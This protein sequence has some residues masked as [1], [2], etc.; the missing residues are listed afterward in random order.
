MSKRPSQFSWKRRQPQRH[1]RKAVVERKFQVESLEERRL[2]AV[3][4]QLVAIS[5]NQGEI[6][7][8]GDVRHIAPRELTFIFDDSQIIDANTLG[9]GIQIVRAGGD[10][11]FGDANDVAIEPGF[12]GVDPDNPNEVIVRFAEALPDDRY[13]IQIIGTGVTPLRNNRGEAFDSQTDL[14]MEF[15]LDLGAQVRAIVPQP[16]THGPGGT[17]EQARNQIEVY[18]ND[19]DL[20]PASA[21]NTDFYKLTLTNDT[22]DNG[23]DTVIPIQEISYD[24]VADKAVLTLA[25]NLDEL[26]GPGTYRLR[27]GTD[28]A[29]PPAPTFFVGSVPDTTDFDSGGAVE[30]RFST[31]TDA[32]S[33][34][35]IVISKAD[36]GLGELPNVAI[37]SNNISLV[38]NSNGVTPSTAQDVIDVMLATGLVTA[39]LISP[40]GTETTDVAAT[41]TDPIEL[42][43]PL[44]GAT[45]DAA[46]DLGLLGSEAKI[47]HSAIDPVPF[48]LDFPGAA[49]EPG[50]RDVDEQTHLL[51]QEEGPPVDQADVD[52]SD[53]E[54]GPAIIAYN[55]QTF[56][57]DDP[58]T[59]LPLTNL[60]TDIQKDRAREI[61]EIYGSLLGIDFI[62]TPQDGLTIVTGDLRAVRRSDSVPTGPLGVIG[63]AGTTNTGL[64]AAVMDNAEIWSDEFAVP[65]DPIPPGDDTF[66]GRLSWFGTAMHEIGHLLGLGHTDELAPFTVMNNEPDLEFDNIPES[67]FPGDHDIVHGQHLHRPDSNDVDLYRVEIADGAQGLF[68]AEVIAERLDNSSLLDSVITVYQEVDV[69]GDIQLEKLAQ[70]DDYFSEDSF[71]ELEL[72]AGVYFVGVSST[73]NDQYNP[74]VSDSSV[75]GTSQGEYDLRLNFRANVLQ[76]L[77]D[78][79][80]DELAGLTDPQPLDGNADGIPGGVF[81]FWFRAAAPSGAEEIGDPRTVFVDKSHTPIAATR[82]TLQNPYTTINEA[83]GQDVFGNPLSIPDG[84][85]ARSGDIVRVVGNGDVDDL[86]GI[87]PYEIGQ[88]SFGQ[89]LSDG[90]TLDLPQGVTMMV[91]AGAVFKF[92]GSAALVGSTSTG[93]DHSASA[94]Q[95][96]GTPDRNVFF[97]SFNDTTVGQ[98]NNPLPDIP[99]SGDWGGVLFNA[100]LDRA[101]GRFDYEAE[102]I[103]LNY[104]NLADIRFGGG[105]VNVGSVVQTIAPIDMRESRATVSYNEITQSASSGISATP[106]TFEE[107]NFHAPEFQP[108]ALTPDGDRIGFTSDYNRIGPDVQGNR[109]LGNS[110]NGMFVRIDTFPGDELRRLTVSGRWDDD[111]I[112]HVVSQ[113]LIVDSEPGGPTGVEFSAPPGTS[114][115][116]RFEL[117]ARPDARLSVDPSVIVKLDGS[118]IETAV[119]AQ[120]ISE[121]Q[122]G[123]AIVFT[124]LM[125]DQYG[126]SGSFDTTNNDS[127]RLPAPGDWGGVYIGQTGS[128]SV[129][130]AIFSYGGGTTSNEGSF[131]GFNVFEIHSA[132]V[133]IAN[134]LFENNAEGTGGQGSETRSGRRSN[135]P[136]AIFVRASQPVL[137]N[138]I[139]RSTNSVDG[140][141]PAAAINI[142]VNALNHVLLADYGRTTGR[143]DQVDGTLD[144]HGPLIVDNRLQMNDIN[145]MLIRSNTLTTQSVWDDADIVH[146]VNGRIYVPDF[147]TYG[148]LRIESSPNESLVVKFS[149]LDPDDM[150]PTI[151]DVAGLV[152]TGRPLDIDDRIGGAI[153]IVGQPGNP[154][155]LSSFFDD[156]VGA[157]LDVNG[158]PQFDTNNDGNGT[159]P[160]P[161]DWES[162]KLD[163]YSHDRNVDVITETE[164]IDLAAAGS[165]GTPVNAQ[166]LGALAANEKGGDDNLRLGFELHGTLSNTA[167]VDVYSFT[168]TGGAEVW[169]DIDRT[170]TSLD[171]VIELVDLNGV[172]LA[173]SDDS[174][175]DLSAMPGAD[176]DLVAG[177]VTPRP[178]GKSPFL[179]VDH[180]TVNPNDAGM[181]LNL[182]GAVGVR[183]TYFVRIRSSHPDLGL[184]ADDLSS[185]Q[186]AGTYQMQVR[187]REVDEVAGSTVQFTDIR[188]ATNAIEIMGQPIHSPLL[189]ETAE[190][191]TDNDTFETAQPIGNILVSDRAAISLS[192]SLSSQD[193]VDWYSFDVVYDSLQLEGGQ[194]GIVFDVDYADG[195]A[196]PNTNLSVF[197]ED[198]QLILFG[199]SSNVADDQPAPGEGSDTDDLSRGSFG[200]QDPFIGTVEFPVGTYYVAVS[201]HARIPTVIAR[202]IGTGDA[203]DKLV[204]LEPIDSLTR[205]ADDRITPDFVT[206][207]A[208]LQFPFDTPQQ[209]ALLITRLLDG[210]PNVERTEN[211]VPFH[212]GD[213]T[214]YVSM[215][216]GLVSTV[217]PFVGTVETTVRGDA[218]PD[219]VFRGIAMRPD[220]HL[221]AATQGTTD[222]TA[223]NFLEIDWSSGDITNT[224]IDDGI[225][226]W[227]LGEET[228]ED[229][230]AG[231]L[232]EGITFG[233]S[234]DTSTLFVVGN[235]GDFDA[236]PPEEPTLPADVLENIVWGLNAT[237]LTAAGPFHPGGVMS[238]D[239]A[240]TAA[241]DL[242]EVGQMAPAGELV[243]G[244]AFASETELFGTTS[245]GSIY[246]MDTTEDR[247]TGVMGAEFISDILN[248]DDEPAILQG[249]TLGPQDVEDGRYARTLLAIDD[250]GTIYAF[251]ADTGDPDNIFLNGESTVLT[252]LGGVNG[253][254]FSTLNENLWHVT[255]FRGSDA[256]HGLEVPFTDTRG[257]A[258]SGEDSFYFGREAGP[259]AFNIGNF[260]ATGDA[261]DFNM[262]GG[263]YGSL[264]TNPFDL[265]DYTSADEPH[266]Y[267]NYFLETKNDG[268][269]SAGPHLDT[270][271]VFVSHETPNLDNSGLLPDDP[272]EWTLLASNIEDDVNLILEDDVDPILGDDDPKPVDGLVFEL[273]DNSGEWRQARIPLGEY[274]GMSDIQLRFDFSS[275]GSM[276]TDTTTGGP[277]L[278]ALAGVELQ[279][280]QTFGVGGT[281]FEFDLGP[282]LILPNAGDVVDG[283]I[284]EIQIDGKST[285]FEFDNDGTVT[286]GHIAVAVEPVDT[287]EV[288]GVKLKRAIDA[289]A[290]F[291]SLL[292]PDPSLLPGGIADL[293]GELIEIN[294]T[295]Y[296][297]DSD[298]MPIDALADPPTVLVTYDPAASAPEIAESL[299]TAVAPDVDAMA[300]QGGV[301]NNLV[302]LS[303]TSAVDLLTPDS[304]IVLTSVDP[305]FSRFTLVVPDP[306]SFADGE[307]L[308]V[309]GTIYE[310]DS[311]GETSNPD[312][313]PP[314]IL[315]PLDPAATVSDTAAAIKD[316]IEATDPAVTVSN[317]SG[318]N[319]DRLIINGASTASLLSTTPPS[320]RLHDSVHL[321]GDRLN[322]EHESDITITQTVPGDAPSAIFVDG[323]N[324]L[325][326]PMGTNIVVK[327]SDSYSAV[328]V[329]DEMI[330]QL[331]G[332][333]AGGFTDTIKRYNQTIRLIGYTADQGPLGYDEVIESDATGGLVSAGGN[334]RAMDNIFQGVF[335]DDLIIG[336]AERGELVFN[337][338]ADTTFSANPAPDPN[339]ILVGDYQ[340][341]ARRGAEYAKGAVFRSFDTNDRLSQSFSIDAPDGSNLQNGQTFTLSDGIEVV[342][343]EYVDRT[344]REGNDTLDVA[345]DSGLVGGTAGTYIGIGTLGDNGDFV[346]GLDVDLISLELTANDEVTFDIDTD[347][348]IGFNSSSFT[349]T[350][351]TYLRVFNEAGEE[352]I[353]SAG[354]NAPGEPPS[355]DPFVFFTAP[356]TGMYYLGISG[357]AR[358]SSIFDDFQPNNDYDVTMPGSGTNAATFLGEYQVEINVNGGT[359]H[360]TVPVAVGYATFD[361]RERVADRI[362]G[363]INSPLVQDT[364]RLDITAGTY[365]GLDR[366]DLFGGDAIVELEPLV[367]TGTTTDANTLRDALLGEGINSVGNAEFLGGDSSAGFFTGGAA[368]IGLESGIVLTTGDANNGGVINTDDGFDGQAS[369]E[370]DDDLDFEFDV[371]TT[372]TTFLEFSFTTES[373]D[374]FFNFVFASEE[375]NEISNSEFNDVFAFF[376]DGGNIALIPGSTNPVSINTV[377]GGNPLGVNPRNSLFY[378]N[379]DP[380]DGGPLVRQFGYD[381]FTD[382]FTAVATDLAPGVHTIKLAISD[383]GD[384]LL[385]S[386]VFLEAGGF[387]SVPEP[388]DLVQGT[389]HDDVGDTNRFRD[390]GQLIIHSNRIFDSAEFSISAGP[391]E[392]DASDGD[393]P[394]QG[395]VSLLREP[396][397]DRL[398]PG[399]TIT[400]NVL[401][402][403]GSGG[404]RFSGDDNSLGPIA[405]VPIGRIIN[406]SIIGSGIDTPE[407]GIQVENNASPTVLNNIVSNLGVGISVDATSVSTVIGGSLF[408]GNGVNSTT[409]VGDF[410]IELGPGEALFV[411]PNNDNYLPQSGSQA[412]D[413]SVDTLGDRPNL[414]T[415]KDPLGISL[416]P[417][418]SPT[419]DQTGQLRV[420]DP[421]VSSPPG[422]GG[423]VFKDRGALDRSDFLGPSAELLTPRDNDADGLD[424]NAN[425]TFV[426]LIGETLSEF[427]VTF[428]DRATA[429]G[430]QQGTGVDGSTVTTDTVMLLRDGVLLEPGLDYT[431]SFDSTNSNIRMTPLAG[432]WISGSYSIVLD[433]MTIA[434]LTGNPLSAN[435]ANGDTAFNINLNSEALLDYGDAPDPTYPTLSGSDGARHLVVA[436]I[437]LGDSITAESDGLQNVAADGDFGDDGVT[438]DTP[439]AIGGTARITVNASSVGVLDAWLD[440]NGDGDWDDAGEQIFAS[441][442]LVAGDNVFSLLIDEVNTVVGDTYA[443]F[444]FSS[445]GGL[446]PTGLA[447]DGEVEDYRVTIEDPQLDFGDAPDFTYHTTLANDGARHVIVPGFQLG[448]SVDAESD[449]QPNGFANGDGSDEDG[450]TFLSPLQKGETST[451]SVNASA[452]GRLDAWFDFDASGDFDDSFAS[453]ERIFSSELLLAGDNVLMFDIP[454]DA[455]VGTSY[456]RFRFSSV[457]GL[458]PMDTTQAAPDGEVED[459]QRQIAQSGFDYGDAPDTYG[460]LVASDGARHV[461]DG[462]HFLGL[463]VDDEVD[464][465]PSVSADADTGDDGIT[466]VTSLVANESATVSVVASTRGL[467]NG[468]ID[469]DQS[470]T[471]E[472]SE[473]IFSDQALVAG[474]NEGLTFTVSAAAVSGDSF[475]R[476]RFSDQSITLPTGEAINGEVEDYQ[477]TIREVDFGDAPF[478]DYP[479]LRPQDGA[480]HAIDPTFFLGATIDSETDGPIPPD[481]DASDDGV[482]LPTTILIGEVTEITVDVSLAGEGV[483]DAWIDLDGANGWEASEQIL[484]AV[485]LTSTTNVITFTIDGNVSA[486]ST[487][488]R[489]RLTRDGVSTPIG[490]ASDGEVEDYAIELVGV[491]FGDAPDT[492]AVNRADNGARHAIGDTY[493]GTAVGGPP[494]AD[495]DGQAMDSGDDGI[496]SSSVSFEGITFGVGETV[497]VEVA[498]VT[499]GT[500][501]LDAWID[502]DGNSVWDPSEQIFA[503]VALTSDREALSFDAPDDANVGTTYARFRISEAGG[504][505]PTGLGATGE[506]EDYLVNLTGP[507]LDFGD[508]PDPTYPTR[509]TSNGARHFIEAG[510][511]LGS[512]VDEESDGQPDGFATGDTDD[513]VTFSGTLQAG[514]TFDAIIDVLD[515]MPAESRFVDIW[516]DF[517]QDGVFGDDADEHAIDSQS[518][519]TGTTSLPITAPLDAGVG[520]TF[521]RVRLSR[522]DDL[523]PDGAATTGEVEDYLIELTAPSFDYGDAPDPTYPTLFANS[524]AR[525][526]IV[527]GFML[528]A[529]VGADMNGQPDDDANGDTGDD[530][531]QFID[532]LELL[533]VASL[534]VIAPTGSPLTSQFDAW[535]DWNGDGDWDDANEQV[536]TN[537]LLSP[538]S[539]NLSVTVPATATIGDTFARF[540]LSSTGNLSPTGATADGEV[541]DYLVTIVDPGSDYGDAP[542]PFPTLNA[543]SDAARHLITSSLFLGLGVSSESDGQPNDDANGD[544][545][546]DGVTLP[547]EFIMRGT[548]QIVVVSSEAAFL[549]AWID[550]NDDGDWDDAHEQIAASLPVVD[551]VNV[552]NVSVLGTED[553]FVNGNTYARFRVSSAGGHSPAGLALDGEVEDYLVTVLDPGLDFGDA[554]D[555]TYPTLFASDGARHQIVPGFTLGAAITGEPDG[556]PSAGANTDSD[557][558]VT[559]PANLTR[560]STETITV[561]AS[562]SG[563]LDAWIDYNRD[564]DWDD[565]G[566]QIFTNLPLNA[567]DNDLLVDVPGSAIAGTTTARFRFSS[568]GRLDPTGMAE[569]GEVEDYLVTIEDLGIDYGDA[570][571]PTFPTLLANDGA[572]HTVVSG[573]SLGLNADGESDGQPSSNASADSGDDGVILPASLTARTTETITVNASQAGQLDAWIDF[574]GDGVWGAGEQIFA[575]QLLVAGDNLLNIDVPNGAV[576][577]S[578]VARFRFSSTGGLSPT[579]AASDG[580]VEDYLVTIGDPGTDFGDAAD[581]TFP[582]LLASNGAR[583]LITE[584]FS[585]GLRIDGE[586][587]GQPSSG[588]NGDGVDDDGVTFPEPL[589]ARTTVDIIVNASQAGVLDAWIDFNQNG[590]WNDVNEQVF[591]SL[592]LSAGDNTLS[593]SVPDGA[594]DGDAPARFRFSSTGGLAPA[595]A[596]VDGEVE[597][598]LVTIV[599]PGL[600]FGDAPDPTYPTLLNNNGARHKIIPGFHLGSDVDEETNG[601]PNDLSTGDGSDEDGILVPGVV[602]IGTTV[603][604]TAT[605][606]AAGF[607]DAWLDLNLDGDWNDAGEQVIAGASLVA[608]SNALSFSVPNSAG[609]GASYARFRFSSDGGLSPTGIAKDGEVEDYRVG[610]V[611]STNSWHNTAAPTNV[612]GEG[613][614]SPLDAL[615][616]I[617]ELDIPTVSDP[618]T[619]VLDLPANPP[620]FYDVTNDGFISPLDALLVINEIPSTANAATSASSTGISISTTS[621]EIVTGVVLSEES[622]SDGL[623]SDHRELDQESS[624]NDAETASQEEI[625]VGIAAGDLQFQSIGADL[626]SRDQVFE[627]N[628]QDE[629]AEELDELLLKRS[630]SDDVDSL[631][632]GW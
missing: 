101:E 584:G 272:G 193:D 204:R 275:A 420:D 472:A 5:P 486:L 394:H 330:V 225:K 270:F 171:T 188:Y 484:T 303:A 599:D 139:I 581:P 317:P 424:Q 173:R 487:F 462:V 601:Q 288:V 36:L 444:R 254:T 438:F 356:T 399:V 106:D 391:S 373:S 9:T 533:A 294:G 95:I 62:E 189:G 553:G 252:G 576:E 411:N 527:S 76:A 174:F 234:G 363:T 49:N 34:I 600:D 333:L 72:E 277:E 631:F 445:V 120:L 471:W 162:V 115:R 247:A 376:L 238:A 103:F 40:A 184:G 582:T 607:L 48:P 79:P 543:S 177:T 401:V 125:N 326:D 547:S 321:N 500:R 407:N 592:D 434:D 354:Q 37:V 557:D 353:T 311:D 562:T 284:I 233:F 240:G 436:G 388:T 307:F 457:G 154:V 138:N 273:F 245:G 427:V 78:L 202:Q 88:D 1:R 208:Q 456:L 242:M 308:E 528:G 251:N 14:S 260:T 365:E 532:S 207:S 96:L 212:L 511:S 461:T 85:A 380:S 572:R 59:E 395:A 27:I 142:N 513:G 549:D 405:A 16:V 414:V 261:P 56:Y 577:G 541:E 271:R 235:R 199:S 92:R 347:N 209:E 458:S 495:P 228:P 578:A 21:E 389:R 449:G 552:L 621:L 479:T 338:T 478:G 190:L 150:D 473:Q 366:V 544:I 322:L 490:L 556:Q 443:R 93:V 417:V 629:E 216:G 357:M 583:H 54:D 250:A 536:F 246:V 367:I 574:D 610:I 345:V 263:A 97:T 57:G 428:S 31:E 612:N 160:S 153:Q 140:A 397:L 422:Q 558:G 555:P 503:S 134:S 548:E 460:T 181:R 43:I 194:A 545:N 522:Q 313:D 163:T 60:I 68:S 6:L 102:G 187:L 374:L 451:I 396:N 236:E 439:L 24:P 112:V 393:A 166:L 276:G 128:A 165:N 590:S 231:I 304:T 123:Q 498:S 466:F 559:I 415:V 197:D 129:D 570:P 616:I 111:D 409:G 314:N 526:V 110:I 297:L 230:D 632:A 594:L 508:A 579:G 563:Q 611:S 178:L 198:G 264:V 39:E 480:R 213:V 98:N 430:T 158:N 442:T 135:A 64:R 561:N 285:I 223:G 412:I 229:A 348:D 256:G 226:T 402:R 383:V 569:D 337:A 419:F 268:A 100:E 227:V 328:E 151:P 67:I 613:G 416:S 91:D 241:T 540:R 257:G 319:G 615:L 432:L 332:E 624:R 8:D 433:N 620:P 10:G 474:N 619:G 265:S 573:F 551:G 74:L 22:V 440:L 534:E 568:A 426:D 623:P 384:D 537:Q 41:V 23:D 446:S 406:N 149:S 315:V 505:D 295:V 334:G 377:N 12:I 485:S 448:A 521:A 99:A 262:P 523:G 196:R 32:S 186:S 509:L 298:S 137:V 278:R 87:V 19:D 287:A 598:Y 65:S 385:D 604:V 554:S 3:G 248:A 507:P 42:L 38:L 124:S 52:L 361:T 375:Y 596:A 293:E 80:P 206:E 496:T 26:G 201:S 182:P 340:L 145:G 566:E 626:L 571:D 217:D 119:S 542:E 618:S 360:S 200:P 185:G 470:G 346:R 218:F 529:S 464:G 324:G 447:N 224:D 155:V 316:A 617:A 368:I 372:D 514:S 535:I 358:T 580:E 267:F 126:A 603:N 351:I 219:A 61:F 331:A 364:A 107:T 131:T 525:H 608:G 280:G 431:F 253:L 58:V 564:G 628:D 452:T 520:A 192:G 567:G 510:F 86:T 425:T 205:I 70:N 269:D 286:N 195:A 183:G 77:V 501:F 168:A 122:A 28:E 349:R 116:D 325:V 327:I 130:H 71:V 81:N 459:Y 450:V 339:Q 18:F 400:N 302:V 518:V 482:I 493:L 371:E 243:T 164:A 497:P 167:D 342:E 136:A 609:E 586:A 369:S 605:A 387:R 585:L 221:Y 2:L 350:A 550:W 453:Q 403:G 25:G 413:S 117:D 84:D 530:G 465:Q 301:D 481:V 141:S 469:F 587:D 329:A 344:I 306:A 597:D 378:N 292:I 392:R 290:E 83:L 45:V 318:L 575:S 17:L 435:R 289:I 352:L 565:F 370:A 627:E 133:R 11:V 546:D 410:A 33:D 169:L 157:G 489:F 602:T 390:Q 121:G 73:G 127:D 429:G 606:S 82:G 105:S 108:T 418:I 362:A 75:G 148:G 335:V 423:N 531:V 13:Q 455:V 44:P 622:T 504:L 282:T 156:S 408:Q 249:L 104:V 175:D 560:L 291:Q 305:I 404:I 47:I 591:T 519:S 463:V 398:A 152:A 144:N 244:L 109:L 20:D 51:Q 7:N 114:L 215:D 30:L 312:A 29:A 258:T 259:G 283:Q 386:A 69:N 55:F 491:D 146:V 147:H 381:G 467:L 483:L 441:E 512:T 421:D 524:G 310:L 359:A 588:A 50:H 299:V 336:F 232:Y 281:I 320:F 454:A 172:V 630:T 35:A 159:S 46:R 176:D 220:G 506:V 211:V 118:R 179:S 515:G 203:A 516:L 191:A 475:A 296:E 214:L 517:N 492:Y 593:I 274:A 266:L 343:F 132:Q 63:I 382:V 341:E 379:N 15:A 595:G 309:N 539:N 614:I 170:S 538:G 113:N 90:V 180:Y 589:V 476:F 494:S 625:L 477:I 323:A 210:E 237:S 53:S 355:T 255:G 502:F 488:A 66:D 222:D 4:P 499:T 89:A 161:G 239:L 300:V 94:L 143:L 468:W 437:M 279:D